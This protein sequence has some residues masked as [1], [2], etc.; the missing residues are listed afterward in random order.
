M[1]EKKYR[2]LGQIREDYFP[3]A[4]EREKRKGETPVEFAIRIMDEIFKKVLKNVG[5]N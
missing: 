3:K 2:T 1:T 4:V 5:A